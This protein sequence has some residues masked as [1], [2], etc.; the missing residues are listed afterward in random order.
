MLYGMQPTGCPHLGNLL[1]LKLA[2]ASTLNKWVCCIADLHALTA[3]AADNQIYKHKI[4]LTTAFVLANVFDKTHTIYIQSCSLAQTCLLWIITCLSKKLELE[5]ASAASE[6]ANVARLLYPSLMAADIIACRPTYVLAGS[7]QSK[8]LEYARMVSKRINT[9]FHSKLSVH[10]DLIPRIKSDMKLVSK[11]M[12]LQTPT[13]KMSKSDANEL[14]SLFILDEYDVIRAKIL[15]A[16]A[17][18]CLHLPAAAAG[19][20]TWPG[21]SNLVEIY[22]LMAG[23]TLPILLKRIGA[24]DIARFKNWLISLLF[25]KM[26]SVRVRMKRWLRRP[27]ALD[28]K[29]GIGSKV[30]ASWTNSCVNHIKY[31]FG[32]E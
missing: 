22:V 20:N 28:A 10:Y 26:C 3:A 29:L 31:V 8:H 15:N 19:L 18:N 30:I 25:I 27:E 12:S 13:A 17:D 6:A 5:R 16:K 9:L 2:R 4:R 1:C 32:L 11:L 14:A 23:I 21:L 7:D 24:I